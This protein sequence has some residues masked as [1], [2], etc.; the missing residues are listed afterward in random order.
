MN[1]QIGYFKY[2]HLTDGEFLLKMNKSLANL[3]K[4]LLNK[5]LTEDYPNIFILGLPRS[6]TTLMSQIIFNH[7]DL[8]CTNNLISRFWEAPLVGANL[9]R[10][11]V[12]KE[13]D[14]SYKS[15]YAK[16]DH[17]TSPHEF[18]YFWRKMLHI[19]DPGNYDPNEVAKKINWDHLKNI[20]VNMNHVF[21]SGMVFKT[22]EY[23]GF[24]LEQFSKLFTKSLFIYVKRN[25]LDTA[26]S[27]AKAR[28]TFNNN[29]TDW[30]GS[31]PLEYNSIKDKPFETQIAGQMFH[32]KA[33][34]EKNI[35]DFPH[36]VVKVN[37]EEVCN[38][39]QKFFNEVRS[40]IKS[41][42]NIEFTQIGNMAPL[43]LSVPVIDAPTTNK[44]RAA[45]K[46]YG[47][48]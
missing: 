10:I 48:L 26:I 19:D 18:S 1:K 33:M 25:P 6:G 27:I 7:F 30:W 37:Y 5:K 21:G 3:E 15:F 28:M 2:D 39:P 23:S 20:I 8:A 16:T 32:L 9:S 45:L 34:F 46:Q 22:L 11:T 12:G 44:L 29:L 35:K 41:L 42:Y 36:K 38:D 13:K 4:E 17:I 14:S 47:L 31:Y 40:K 24:F 43:K